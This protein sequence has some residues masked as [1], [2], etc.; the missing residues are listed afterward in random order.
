M[1]PAILVRGLRKAYGG[2]EAVRGIDLEVAAGE[3]FALL[4]PNGAGK[5]STVEILEGYRTADAGEVRVLGV[6]PATGGPAFRARIGIVLQEAGVYP[7]LSAREVLGLFAG[8]Y[9]APRDVDEVLEL[10][11]LTEH[12]DRRVRALSGGQAR[13][14]DVA[15]ALIGRPELI[16]LDEPTTGFD[17]S[18]RRAAWDVIARLAEGG[19]TVLLTTHY[20]DE[21]RALAHRV[22]VMR[23]GELVAVGPPEELVAS[24]ARTEVR[25]RQPDGTGAEAL[26][27]LAGGTLVERPGRLAIAVDD[28]TRALHALTAWAVERGLA[29]ESLEVVRPTLEDVYLAL[30]TDETAAPA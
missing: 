10:V 29:L 18:A 6:D 26:A 8:Y 16:F 15:L 14:L 25:F 13:R 12:A 5:T 4:G 9:P 1:T 2:H 24:L 23:D 20:M 30:T 27:A 19:T 21:A 28:P 7:Y 22:G 11:G 3:V 17:P